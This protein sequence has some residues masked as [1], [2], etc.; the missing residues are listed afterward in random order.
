MVVHKNY[1]DIAL[2]LLDKYIDS[3]ISNIYDNSMSINDS[4]N[5]LES[6][7]GYYL[8]RLEE[9]NLMNKYKKKIW[10]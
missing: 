6:I 1:K 2:E 7:C 10:S 5:N 8:A 4:L 3:E 9:Y